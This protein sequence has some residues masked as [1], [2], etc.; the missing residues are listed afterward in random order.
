MNGQGAGLLIAG[1]GAEF[2]ECE[3]LWG[4]TEEGFGDA[5]EA[6]GSVGDVEVLLTG[7]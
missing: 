5:M 1:G 3:A 7:R 6:L 4:V 2:G